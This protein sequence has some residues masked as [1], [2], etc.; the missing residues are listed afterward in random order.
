MSKSY[1]R[2]VATV[3]TAIGLVVSIYFLWKIRAM[4]S[5]FD[6]HPSHVVQRELASTPS[7]K[8]RGGSDFPTL[9]TID[10]I[11]TDLY[12]DDPHRVHS[13]NWRV[14]IELF[15]D[16]GRATVE[17]SEAGLKNVIIETVRQQ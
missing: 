5:G 10:D 6:R 9:V 12:S 7:A 1:P 11:L 13:L 3:L 17:K 16:D 2:I 15:D 14:E 8:K 4:D